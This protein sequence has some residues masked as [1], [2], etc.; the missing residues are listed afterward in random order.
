RDLPSFPT[1][2]SSD[3]DIVMAKQA[4]IVTGSDMPQFFGKKLASLDGDASRSKLVRFGASHRVGGVAIAT[5]P[6]VHTNGVS[7]AF[8]GGRR[9]EEHTSEL[10]SREN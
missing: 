7:A 9:S 5:V 1:R 6:A 3:L 2:R 4:L 8:I 10:Q